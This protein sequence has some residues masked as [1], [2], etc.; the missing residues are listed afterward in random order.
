MQ[1]LN[2][3]RVHQNVCSPSPSPCVRGDTV[4]INFFRKSALTG[5][6]S[7]ITRTRR[8]PQTTSISL[9]AIFPTRS[10]TRFSGKLSLLSVL[11]LRLESCGIWRLAVPVATGLLLSASVLMLKRPWAPWMASGLAP[12]PFVATGQTRRVSPRSISNKPCSRWGWLRPRHMA[13]ITFPRTASIAMTW[14]STRLQPGK[15]PATLAI[16]PPTRPR[17][18]WCPCSRT[19]ATSSSAACKPTAVSRSLRWTAMR[20]RRW[21]SASLTATWSTV[22]LSSAAYVSTPSLL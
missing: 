7:P 5:P 4:L 19:S 17:T 8:I 3:R 20:T 13:I 10:T 6:T 14:L 18:I 12:A 22:A 21:P 16:W 9:L 2:G 11:S 1:T 15:L